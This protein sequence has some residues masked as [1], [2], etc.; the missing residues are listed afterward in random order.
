M[1][2]TM[3]STALCEIERQTNT[4]TRKKVDYKSRSE[5]QECTVK[6]RTQPAQLGWNFARDCEPSH[7]Y[8]ERRREAQA[9]PSLLHTRTHIHS[10][11]AQ[12]A[13]RVSCPPTKLVHTHKYYW[14]SLSSKVIPPPCPPTIFAI[15]QISLTK[16]TF[17]ENYFYNIIVLYI[18]I[19]I[20]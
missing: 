10:E 9:N 11:S 12:L 5:E 18:S 8:R 13:M 15:S 16:T 7:T 1:Q 3:L 19:N 20:F 2:V 6:R 14:R 17:I 4:R